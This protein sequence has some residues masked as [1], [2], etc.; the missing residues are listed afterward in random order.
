MMMMMIIITTGYTPL[1]LNDPKIG[2]G[3]IIQKDQNIWKTK[4]IY[5]QFPN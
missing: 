2:D 1:K 3:I 4:T 5:E